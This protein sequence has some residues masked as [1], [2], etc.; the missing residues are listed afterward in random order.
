MMTESIKQ[1]AQQRRRRRA[2]SDAGAPA[3][4][5]QQVAPEPKK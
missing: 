2:G 5:D 4:P 1:E 3:A